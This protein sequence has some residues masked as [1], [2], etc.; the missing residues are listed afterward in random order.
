GGSGM[1]V[2]GNGSSTTHGTG[3]A[4]GQAHVD[5]QCPSGEPFAVALLAFTTLAQGAPQ[6]GE[7]P[8]HSCRRR[9]R[10]RPGPDPATPGT[11]G[12]GSPG[13]APQA[14]P[15]EGAALR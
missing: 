15:E 7:A 11:A 5:F 14:P 9:C 4:G 13:A 2:A 6:R 10:A 1:A 3:A 12:R 8:S